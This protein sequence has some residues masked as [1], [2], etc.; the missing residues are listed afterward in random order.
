MPGVP[1][2]EGSDGALWPLDVAAGIT[3]KET[4]SQYG[5]GHVAELF[6]QQHPVDN[7]RFI[8]VM[9]FSNYLSK[10]FLEAHV[11]DLDSA[12]FRILNDKGALLRVITSIP[13]TGLPFYEAGRGPGVTFG[14]KAPYTLH[15]SEIRREQVMRTENDL[16]RITEY[17]QTMFMKCINDVVERGLKIHL[18][19]KETPTSLGTRSFVPA[20]NHT[21]R[22]KDSV[23]F[24]V[25][26][27]PDPGDTIVNH[28]T[29]HNNPYDEHSGK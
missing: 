28:G 24:P 9:G 25:K 4:C 6:I 29:R 10:Q 23:D 15:L 21:A 20:N 22:A 13:R 1:G 18:P 7:D 16:L 26:E 27:L 11:L 14:N 3:G 5:S 2:G 17:V 19:L 8:N 12:Y